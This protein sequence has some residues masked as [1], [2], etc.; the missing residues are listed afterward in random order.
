MPNISWKT[1]GAKW[2]FKTKQKK[3]GG[4][5]EGK[6]KEKRQWSVKAKDTQQE[7]GVP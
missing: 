6:K 1:S 2:R 7:I 4:G 5:G 3:K